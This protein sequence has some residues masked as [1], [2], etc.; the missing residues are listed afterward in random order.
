MTKLIKS[1]PKKIGA[2]RGNRRL[3]IEGTQLVNAGFKRGDFVCLSYAD[4]DHEQFQINI[5]KIDAGYDGQYYR[6]TGKTIK[7]NGKESLILDVCNKELSDYLEGYPTDK[8]CFII[9]FY[10]DSTVAI[11]DC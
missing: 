4:K 3:W 10:D 6:I 7:S 9:A 8:P 5:K 2:N 1:M 11:T